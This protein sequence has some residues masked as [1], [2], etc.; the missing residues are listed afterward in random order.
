M[1]QLLTQL[2]LIATLLIGSS[3]HGEAITLDRIIAIVNN[4]PINQSELRNELEMVK[5]QLR[6]QTSNLPADAILQTQ[7]LDKLILKHLQ[8]QATRICHRAQP[9]R[10]PSL[11]ARYDPV[12]HR[13]AGAL[14]AQISQ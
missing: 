3:A 7:V 12:M 11:A 8:Q 6:Q 13:V 2:T 14:S 1:K 9:R 4:E 10:F 5:L